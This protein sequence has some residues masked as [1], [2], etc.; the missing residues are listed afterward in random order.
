[1]NEKP[2]HIKT[3]L[4]WAL[5]YY[6]RGWCVIPIGFDKKPPRGFKWEK[7]QITRPDVSDLKKWFANGKYKN[8][9]VVGGKVSGGVTILDFDSM[10]LYEVWKGCYPHYAERLPKV[11]TPRGMHV[12]FRSKLNKSR[13]FGKIDL[14]S[15]RK[16]AVL[17][18]STHPNGS[19]YEWLTPLPE[20]KLPELDPLAW[21]LEKVTEDPE[22]TEDS[23]DT[24]D[25][26]RRRSHSCF[27]GELHYLDD[28]TKNEVEK[29]IEGTL[30]KKKGQRNDAVF[31]L[32]QWL[33]AI[34]DLRD[35]RAKKLE[36]IVREWHRRAYGVIGTKPFS[37]TWADFVHAWK[38]V[39]W[40]KGDVMLS[41]AIKRVLEGKTILPE[42]EEYDTEE[43]R[44]LLKLCYE[45][46]QGVG[47]RPFFLAS[48]TAGGFVGLSHRKAYKLLETFV[49]DGKLD[50]VEKHTATKATRYRYI[51]N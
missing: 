36:P 29:G 28:E 9:A 7:Y 40:P 13:K 10:D 6:S 15:E 22:E 19:K 8:L 41:Q 25:S 11:R 23:E 51:A 18:P 27:C 4:E 30:P 26:E 12:F 38:R 32:C 5:E 47:D 50:P 35:L 1:M 20:G 16:Y 17:P 31:P 49:E 21:G 37:D 43:A 46:Q 39:K 14:I 2:D 44:C 33:K 3:L 24:H 48:R 45:L 34:P 42:A